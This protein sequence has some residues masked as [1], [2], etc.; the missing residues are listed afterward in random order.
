MY[1]TVLAELGAHVPEARSASTA[2]A[3]A[4]A[5][6]GK[7]A[8]DLQEAAAGLKLA[9]AAKESLRVGREITLSGPIDRAGCGLLWS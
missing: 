4:Q 3:A 9:D 2:A 1:H 7:P 6:T 8:L 5:H